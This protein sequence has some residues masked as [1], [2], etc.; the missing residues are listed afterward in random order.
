MAVDEEMLIRS[1]K[2]AEAKL[3]FC[4][5]LVAYA[6]VNAGLFFLWYF[7][8]Q[9]FPWFLFVVFFWGIGVAARGL[10]YYK[11]SAS[12]DRMAEAEYKRMIERGY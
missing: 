9:G 8:D 2:R 7:Y 1:R 11:H 5:D 12:F 10:T 6:L 4:T 3:Y